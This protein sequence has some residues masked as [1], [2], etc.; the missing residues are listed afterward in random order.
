[1]HKK[2]GSFTLCFRSKKLQDA[3][4]RKKKFIRNVLLLPPRRVLLFNVIT[5]NSTT[6]FE[7]YSEHETSLE[8]IDNYKQQPWLC[9]SFP[10]LFPLPPS[11]NRSYHFRNL[12]ALN[13][14]IRTP[15]TRHRR[16]SRSRNLTRNEPRFRI[17]LN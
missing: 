3:L 15:L 7:N 4:Y 16:K 10:F 1:M 6:F 2:I 14:P 12:V 11:F 13:A 8:S 5:I 17:L 9:A